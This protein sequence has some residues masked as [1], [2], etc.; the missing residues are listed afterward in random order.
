MGVV[1][2]FL[3]QDGETSTLDGSLLND[4]LLQESDEDLVAIAKKFEKKYV[5]IF[6]IGSSQQLYTSPSIYL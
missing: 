4:P 3:H 2:F 1:I 6:A 5:S